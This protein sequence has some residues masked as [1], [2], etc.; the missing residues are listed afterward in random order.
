MSPQLPKWES[1]RLVTIDPR[2][3]KRI[4]GVHPNGAELWGRNRGSK[5]WFL[6]PIPYVLGESP[7]AAPA[8]FQV[9]FRTPAAPGDWAA[10]VDF[11]EE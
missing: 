11:D 9:R 2:G 10:G 3:I 1:G 5:E 6:L 4:T 8:E 7:L